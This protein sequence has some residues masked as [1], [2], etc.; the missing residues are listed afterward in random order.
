MTGHDLIRCQDYML[1]LQ[2]VRILRN[3]IYYRDGHLSS[4]FISGSVFIT[5]SSTPPRPAAFARCISSP[6]RSPS[7]VGFDVH[8]FDIGYPTTKGE[9][10]HP[11]L[12]FR[13]ECMTDDLQAQEPN[14]KLKTFQVIPV[15]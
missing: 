5:E 1:I 2:Q 13:I 9:T 11:C 4:I 10:Q 6:V 15:S 7:Q 14:K 12:W 8:G 3:E